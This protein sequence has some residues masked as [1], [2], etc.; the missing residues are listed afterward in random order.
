MQCRESLFARHIFVCEYLDFVAKSLDCLE[1]LCLFRAQN[2]DDR[3]FGLDDF[4]VVVDELVLIFDFLVS[5]IAGRGKRSLHDQGDLISWSTGKDSPVC[6]RY[7]HAHQICQE[8]A[9]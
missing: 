6:M 8:L 2:F 9:A 4:S 1:I 7:E 3:V 5:A